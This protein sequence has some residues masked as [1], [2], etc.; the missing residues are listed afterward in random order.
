MALIF[1]E[2]A[3]LIPGLLPFVALL[4]LFTIPLALPLLALG[5]LAAPAVGGWLLVRRARGAR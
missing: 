3:V 1:L 5:L 2:L 4:V